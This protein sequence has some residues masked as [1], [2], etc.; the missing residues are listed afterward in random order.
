MSRTELEEKVGE[1][2]RRFQT[3]LDR[4][5]KQELI[6][7]T[8]DHHYVMTEKGREEALR[9]SID[10]EMEPLLLEKPEHTE[11]SLGTTEYQQFMKF[12]MHTGVVPLGLIQQTAAHVWDGGDFHDLKWVA[13]AMQEMGIR[14]DLRGRWFHRWRSYLKA[15]IPTDLPSE[16]FSSESRKAEEKKEAERKEGAGKRDYILNEDDYPIYVGEGGGDLDYKDALDLSKIRAIRRKDLAHATTAGSMADDVTKIFGAFKAIMGEKAEGK[17]F[18]VKPGNGGYEVVEVDT[19]KPMLIPQPQGNKP[20]ASFFVDNDGT[21]REVPPGQPVV[22][23]KESPKPASTSG[24]HYLIDQRTGEVKEVAAGQPVVIIRESA[25]SQ[26]FQL[27]GKDGQPMIINLDNLPL[28]TKLEEHREKMR[29]DEESHQVKIDIAKGL[30]EVIKNL[31]GA[32]S[33]MGGEE[34]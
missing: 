17:S 22:I 14:Q 29:R 19:S 15:A 28:L 24:T 8:G 18:V 6:K 27:T 4:W 31:G 7:D 13:Q 5:E 30:K 21:V 9:A 26:P 11:E 32:L 20:G 1:S 33:E 23:I 12:G 10:Q 16:F 25:P 3:Q 2:Y 34:K